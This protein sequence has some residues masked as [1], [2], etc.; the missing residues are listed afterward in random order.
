[1]DDATFDAFYD[2]TA[3]DIARH[4]YLLT[5][6]PHRAVHA[7]QRAYARAY[8]DWDVLGPTPNLESWVRMIASDIALDHL[9]RARHRITARLPVDRLARGVNRIPTPGGRSAK[10]SGGPAEDASGGAPGGGP[11]DG[12][13]GGPAQP[14]PKGAP[15]PPAGGTAG[16]RPP[17][18]PSPP[19]P[20][21]D[22]A[23]DPEA[24]IPGDDQWSTD[25]A[26]LRALLGVP[27]H[28]R[29][30]AVLHHLAGMTAEEIAAETESTVGSTVE[31]IAMADEQLVDDI[32]A[33]GGLAP[34]GPEAQE[35]IAAMM[36]DLAGRYR[37]ELE[38]AEL[39]RTDTQ[40]RTK[41][42][43]GVVGAAVL[44]LLV[45]TVVVTF[46]PGNLPDERAE[47]RASMSARAAA[48]MPL[49]AE[50]AKPPINIG[51]STAR[52]QHVPADKQELV[53]VM[54]TASHDGGTFITVDPADAPANAP[55]QPGRELP[56]SPKVAFRGA[57]A[58]GLSKQQ[59]VYAGDFL[60]KAAEGSL[61]SVVFEVEYDEDDQV[62]LI[63]ENSHR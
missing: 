2:R 54:G 18:E 53:H 5:A 35:R 14:A 44:G 26:L 6:S 36:R 62:I 33:L 15:R 12:P 57:A 58:F 37:P 40:G 9:Y 4:V 31:R 10:A 55:Q 42:L 13:D 22:P 25:V 45:Y 39:V 51:R 61:A 59:V 41:I 21:L 48:G 17:A 47:V 8:A 50:A 27:A 29:R 16:P 23:P 49:V 32:D 11:H 1:M 56:L 38:T 20:V 43:I 19:V 3:A 24:E 30:A 7:T 28:R 46:L 63:R 34:D 60:A 52:A